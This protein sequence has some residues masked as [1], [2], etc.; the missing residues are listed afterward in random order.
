MRNLAS[1]WANKF[2]SGAKFVQWATVWKALHYCTVY[3]INC[4][5][6]TRVVQWCVLVLYSY[7][8]SAQDLRLGQLSSGVEWSGSRIERRDGTGEDRTG[9][10]MTGEDTECRQEC[11][12]ARADSSDRTHLNVDSYMYCI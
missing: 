1:R 9:Q 8:S 5:A 2:G 12:M 3:V 6:R 10:G 4:A 7:C 11:W